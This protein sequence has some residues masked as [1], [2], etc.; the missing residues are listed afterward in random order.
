MPDPTPNR[1]LWQVM[2]DAF[3]EVLRPRPLHP[4]PERIGG[5]A[6][7][8]AIVSEIQRR[9]DVVLPDDSEF[10]GDTGMEIVAW[11]RAEADRAEAGE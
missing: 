2:H 7:L 9:W 1:P 4:D 10:H 11:L 8:R 6:M 3:L 5:A